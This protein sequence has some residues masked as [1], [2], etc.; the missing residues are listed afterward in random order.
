MLYRVQTLRQR[1]RLLSREELARTAT[2]CGRLLTHRASSRFSRMVLVATLV[3]PRRQTADNILLPPLYCVEL[4]AIA[5][6]AIRLRGFELLGRGERA[7]AVL[8]EW[9]CSY[10]ESRSDSSFARDAQ[11]G[12]AGATAAPLRDPVPDSDEKFRDY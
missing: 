2:V 1:G 11:G 8:Q 7:H 10:A 3:D 5:T 12:R 4:L 6:L 9:L